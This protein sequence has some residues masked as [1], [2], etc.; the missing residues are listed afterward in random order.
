MIR[1][2]EQGSPP[3]DV[4]PADV[5]IVGAGAAGIALAVELSRRG[6]RVLLL[7]AGGRTPEAPTQEL[8]RS[9]VPGRSHR[10]VHEGRFRVHG[11]TTTQWGGQILELQ[12]TDFEPHPWIAGSGWPFPKSELAPF[13]ARALAWEGI[14]A[15]LLEDDAVWSALREQPPALPGLELYL[16]RWCPEPNFAR[17]HRQA[18]ETNP[19]LEL[20]L[21]ANAVSLLFAGEAADGILCRT[22]GGQQAVFRGR[23][24]VFALG[25]IE[26]S[27]F[28]LQPRPE[29]SLPWNQ[30]GLLGRHFQDHIDSDAATV[31]PRFPRRFHQTFDS[32]FLHGHKY[33]PKLRF[34]PAVKQ[35]AGVLNAGGTLFSV[36]EADLT[37]AEV[38]TTAKHL[39]RGHFAEL[40]P[41][42]LVG[43]L[44]HSPLV[45]QQ[46]WR[47]TVQHRS[48]HPKEAEIRLRVHCEQEPRSASRI[49]LSDERDALGLLRTRIDWQISALELQTIR[50]FVQEAARAL[51]GQAEVLPHPDL[52]TPDDRFLAQCQ[53]SF[54]HMGGMRMAATAAAGVVDLNLKLHGTPNV[55]I[56]SG[57]VFPTSGFSNPTHT[58]L[59]LAARMAE[60]LTHL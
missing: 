39:L 25:A 24:Y 60:H 37:L 22:L 12:E 30:S 40:T 1:D 45:A 47:Y 8:Y 13:Y 29:S 3:S 18:L 10:G 35:A 16:S 43:L 55:Y 33:N 26:S 11:G 48:F 36:S 28:F 51:A 6:Q 9:H 34:T 49:T 19:N 23:R 59:A 58:L 44:R 57:A 2:L 21:H 54:H 7:E 50:T 53:D 14:A 20:W 56:C 17:L 5:V 52:F 32:I 42:R 46:A 4:D 31:R 41:A 15:S 38:K 27:R